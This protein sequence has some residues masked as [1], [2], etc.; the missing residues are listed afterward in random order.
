MR[1]RRLRNWL[2]PQPHPPHTRPSPLLPTQTPTVLQ[3]GHSPGAS[4]AA[5]A[6][7]RPIDPPLSLPEPARGPR[8]SAAHASTPLGP[9]DQQLPLSNG[10]LSASPFARTS[11]QEEYVC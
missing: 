4:G 1:C 7:V 9:Y 3:P 8:D 10:W 2:T 6:P 5:V 11:W